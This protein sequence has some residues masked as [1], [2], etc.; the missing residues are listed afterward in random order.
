LD[1]RILELRHKKTQGEIATAA[2]FT[3]PNML[4]I[5][6]QGHSKLAIDRVATLA[7]AL[8]VDPK[9]LLRLALAQ[10]GNVT[11]ARV[12]DEIIGTVV[13]HNELGWLEVL[14]EASG[15][16][17]PAITS[18]GRAAVLAIFGK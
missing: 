13:T 18:R 14:R 17:D 9:F 3:N 7:H 1:R 15:N 12:Y 2:G 11:M 10:D 16:S 6:K 4:T 8:E 5:M